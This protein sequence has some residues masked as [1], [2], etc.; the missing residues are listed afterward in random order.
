MSRSVP[1]WRGRTDDSSIPPRVRMRVFSRFD[2]ICQCGCGMTINPGER[3]QIDHRIALIAGGDNCENN[4][5][6]ILEEHHKAK[7]ARDVKEKAKV[8]RIRAKHRGIKLRKKGR[9]LSHPFLRRKMDGTV[10]PK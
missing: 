2:G 7:T 10:V 6:P 5:V 1:E 4:L 8:Y 9:S 3:W